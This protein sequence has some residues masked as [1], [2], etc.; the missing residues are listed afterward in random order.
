ML[1]FLQLCREMRRKCSLW[2]ISSSSQFLKMEL[3]EK[4]EDNF[5]GVFNVTLRTLQTL[6][7]K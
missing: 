3:V 1:A 4:K 7:R 6:Y 2:Y 5:L